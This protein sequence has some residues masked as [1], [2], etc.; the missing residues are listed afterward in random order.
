MLELKKDKGTDYVLNWKSKGVFNSKPKPLYT[1]FL[2]S[3]NLTEYR[4]RIKFDK[5]PLAVEQKNYLSKIVNVYI[6]YDLDAW[7]RNSTNDFKFK[8]CLF[9]A[10]NAVKNSDK[11]KYVCSRYGII[12]DFAGS[13]T[14]GND[15]ARNDAIL[16]LI[17]VH[18]LMLIIARVSFGYGSFSLPEKKFINFS[19]ANTK[20]CLSL[21]YNPNN[22][23][24]F[25]TGKEIFEFKADNKNVNFPTQF[26]LRNISNGFSATEFREVSSDGNVYDFSVDYRSSDKSDILN[27]HK[28]LINK[29]KIK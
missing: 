21:H 16:V 12:F 1:A 14:F 2:H 3:I 11:E 19:K 22:S 17:I 20:F 24:L 28:H 4:I 26:C 25:V 27:I 29:N 9:G 5:D 8:N 7:P 23:Y 13:W 18:H 10:T 15:F 6:V